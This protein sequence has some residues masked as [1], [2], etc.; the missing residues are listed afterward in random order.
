MFGLNV[1]SGQRKFKSGEGIQW[2]NIDSI[3]RPKHE[4]DVVCDG[5]AVPYEDDSV[6]YFVLSQVYEHFGCG[7]A[8]GLLKEAFRVLRPGGSLIISVPNMKALAGRWLGGEITEYIFMVNT[9]GAYMGNE[10]DRHRWGT[11]PESLTYHVKN[12]ARW[13]SVNKFDGREITG[14]DVALDW[15]IT[16]LEAKK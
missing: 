4:P 15:W 2:V 1:G 7:E 12:S 14:M 6:D 3:S 5:S 11:T 9:Y 10:A 8:V 13:T 16:C